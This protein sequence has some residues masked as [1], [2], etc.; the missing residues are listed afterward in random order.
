M[1][2]KSLPAE[3]A[4]VRAGLAAGLPGQETAIWSYPRYD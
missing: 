2:G 4:R 3:Q 1:N